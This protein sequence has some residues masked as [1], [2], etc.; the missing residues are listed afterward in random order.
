LSE[1]L[2]SGKIYACRGENTFIAGFKEL[3][4]F[5]LC[6]EKGMVYSV[7]ILMVIIRTARKEN[8]QDIP[9]SQDES[10]TPAEWIGAL[11]RPCASI[12]SILH[13]S[14]LKDGGGI[15]L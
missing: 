2:E 7:C 3:I 5:F 12:H 15:L 9:P 8:H 11:S 1:Q 14:M 6:P 13:Y 10:T 4:S